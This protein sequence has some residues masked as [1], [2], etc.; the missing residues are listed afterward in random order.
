MLRNLF[1]LKKKKAFE[2]LSIA[3]HIFQPILSCIWFFV[4]YLC[5]WE[6]MKVWVIVYFYSKWSETVLLYLLFI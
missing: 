6:N 4:R 1:D 2:I 5:Q 3:F